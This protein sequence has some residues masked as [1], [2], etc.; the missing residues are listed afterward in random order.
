L[1]RQTG[2]VAIVRVSWASPGD[3][4]SELDKIIRLS[5]MSQVSARE[6]ALQP[7]KQHQV[8][9]IPLQQPAQRRG[10]SPAGQAKQ[11]LRIG[12]RRAAHVSPIA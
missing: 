9:S 4:R 8:V 6:I 5:Y 2:A 10:V 1:E 7:C 12:M 3:N 11:P